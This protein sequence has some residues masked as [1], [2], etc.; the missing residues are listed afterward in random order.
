MPSQSLYDQPAVPM[1]ICGGVSM[2]AR[3][4]RLAQG[5]WGRHFLRLPSGQALSV[6]RWCGQLS[7]FLGSRQDFRQ[8]MSELLDHVK[9]PMAPER[10]HP[11]DI[12][13]GIEE[14]L[15]VWW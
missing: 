14:V 9:R 11:G 8:L 10:R 1:R 3:C 6:S 15:S 5:V 7:L 4:R 13:I 12:E 2:A